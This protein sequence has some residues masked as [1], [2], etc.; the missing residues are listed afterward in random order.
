MKPKS[1]QS[2]QADP[3]SGPKFCERH[4]HPGC[5]C[6]MGNVFRF[7]EPLLLLEIRNSPGASGYDI[8]QRLDGHSLTGTTIDKAAVYRSLGVL[9]RNGMTEAE[10][11][12]SVRGAGRK[13][14]KLTP[15]GEEHLREWADLLE[16]LAK[17]LRAFVRDARKP[18]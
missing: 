10:W 7:V 2:L 4:G 6:G 3:A 17:G 11:T 18:G 9:E 8:L 5:A 16:G 14:Y 13:A 12:E 1:I 15:K